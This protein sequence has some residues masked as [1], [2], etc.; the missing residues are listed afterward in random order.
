MLRDYDDKNE[1]N[2][3]MKEKFCIYIYTVFVSEIMYEF[4]KMKYILF[5]KQNTVSF[6][7]WSN[8]FKDIFCNS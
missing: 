4:C 3:V 7:N 5:C 2:S 1:I 8:F 6:F